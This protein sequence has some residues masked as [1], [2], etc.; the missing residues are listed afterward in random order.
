[1]QRIQQKIREKQEEM[2][3]AQAT[4]AN[5]APAA[6]VDEATTEPVRPTT[7]K[8]VAARKPE[9]KSKTNQSTKSG[10]LLV[11]DEDAV[12][13]QRTPETEKEDADRVVFDE[14]V[15]EDK[16][17]LAEVARSNFMK[18]EQK[19]KESLNKLHQT[20]ANLHEIQRNLDDATYAEVSPQL[21]LSKLL[22]LLSMF[23]FD[24]CKINSGAKPSFWS[25]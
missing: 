1:M 8:L 4:S 5:A 7:R 9:A 19:L 23:G 22:R 6:I 14:K 16:M 21:S 17:A 24:C 12:A 20:E 13:S 25:K 18:E 2:K 15:L 3:R 11:Y 10:Y